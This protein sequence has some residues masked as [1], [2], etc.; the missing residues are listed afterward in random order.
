MSAP[1]K[2]EIAAAVSAARRFVEGC[3]VLDDR[4]IVALADENERLRKTWHIKRCEKLDGEDPSRRCRLAVDH[5]CDCD[6]GELERMRAEIELLRAERAECLELLG[7]LRRM[8]ASPMKSCDSG[9]VIDA[10]RVDELCEEMQEKL[11]GQL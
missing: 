5:E 7:T 2:E 1:S 10:R 4:V 3:S 9:S 8:A 6:F 11:R